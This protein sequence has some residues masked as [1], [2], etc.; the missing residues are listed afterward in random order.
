MLSLIYRTHSDLDTLSSWV[1]TAMLTLPQGVCSV[2][3]DQYLQ[4]CSH[5]RPRRQQPL[6]RD[7][8]LMYHHACYFAGT[9]EQQEQL[10]F[11]QKLYDCFSSIGHQQMQ[12][13]DELVIADLQHHAASRQLK[14]EL[15]DFAERHQHCTF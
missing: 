2:L 9:L 14:K 4:L 10:D 7:G 12:Q 3:D 15:R 1:H 6:P 8:S 11:Q 5:L 13:G